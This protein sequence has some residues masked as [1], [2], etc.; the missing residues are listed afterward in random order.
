MTRPTHPIRQ[1]MAFAMAMAAFVVAATMLLEFD[2]AVTDH[3]SG[4]GFMAAATLGGFAAGWATADLFG[5]TDTKGILF[6]CLGAFAATLLGAAIA[7]LIALPWHE[8]PLVI[9]AMLF[10]VASPLIAGTWLVFMC[11]MQA[12]AC[13]ERHAEPI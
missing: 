10:S 2:T 3:V 5:R 1:N 6:A 8:L 11:L 7:G 12:I 4:A 13:H 9:L